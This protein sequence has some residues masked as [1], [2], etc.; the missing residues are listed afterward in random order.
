LGVRDVGECPNRTSDESLKNTRNSYKSVYDGTGYSFLIT[1][2]FPFIFAKAVT[3]LELGEI[4]FHGL[5]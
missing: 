1:N 3:S 4:N 2:N 5:M